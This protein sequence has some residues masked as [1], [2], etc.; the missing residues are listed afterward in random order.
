MELIEGRLGDPNATHPWYTFLEER[1]PIGDI[2]YT[3]KAF[4]R[5]FQVTFAGGSDRHVRELE[6]RLDEYTS[7]ANPGWLYLKATLKLR[8]NSPEGAS[9]FGVT[10]KDS[11]MVSFVVD[12]S[13]MVA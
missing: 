11:E 13:V 4:L 8:D 12:Y 5:G 3:A 9:L 1:I 2:T 7:A 6:V 10:V